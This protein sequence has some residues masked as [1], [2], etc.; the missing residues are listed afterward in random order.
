M[1]DAPPPAETELNEVQDEEEDESQVIWKKKHS[2]HH[3][4]LTEVRGFRF[5]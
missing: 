4:R 3:M 1:D 2:T 5:T